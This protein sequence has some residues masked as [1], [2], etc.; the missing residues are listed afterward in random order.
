MAHGWEQAMRARRESLG[1]AL[2]ERVRPALPRDASMK[3]DR[4]SALEASF[5]TADVDRRLS[6]LTRE[7]LTTL[8]R[9]AVV[10]AAEGTDI[11]G[12]NL[13]FK[14]GERLAAKIFGEIQDDF[15]TPAA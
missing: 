2:G 11:I 15:D 8:A 10:Y 6:K 14:T 3:Q 1:E 13:D 7:Q 12:G 4:V 5:T 9:V